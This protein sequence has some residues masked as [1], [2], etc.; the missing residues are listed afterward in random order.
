MTDEEA[1]KWAERFLRLHNSEFEFDLIYEDDDFTEE[2]PDDADWRKVRDF[3]YQ[4]KLE[5]SWDD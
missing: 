2:F 4:A 3:M 5:V 1:K